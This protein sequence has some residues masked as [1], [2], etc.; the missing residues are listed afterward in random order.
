MLSRLTLTNF[1]AFSGSASVRIAPI[2]LLFGQN[3][4]G[5]SSVLQSLYLLLQTMR[6][7]EPSVALLLRTR[8]GYVDLGSYQ[9]ALYGHDPKQNQMRVRLDVAVGDLPSG[10]TNLR[11]HTFSNLAQFLVTPPTTDP[12][13]IQGWMQHA[14]IESLG[15]EIA[16]D[17][18]DGELTVSGFSLFA[19]SDAE[20]LASY[21][22]EQHSEEPADPSGAGR[23]VTP[24]YERIFV[25]RSKR[26]WTYA[27]SKR[28]MYLGRLLEG[29]TTETSREGESMQAEV[30]F[31]S[32][33]PD[34]DTFIDHQV[35]RLDRATLA[36]RWFLPSSHLRA[37]NIWFIPELRDSEATDDM[38]PW[39][40]P[41]SRS[42][43]TSLASE[44][45]K[46]IRRLLKKEFEKTEYHQIPRVFESLV[47][48]T[49]DRIES[50]LQQARPIGPSRERAA[51]LYL[52][53]GTTPKYVGFAGGDMPEMLFRQDRL[54]DEINQWLDKLDVGYSVEALPIEHSHGGMGNMFEIRLKDLSSPKITVSL[55]DVG[56][57]VTQILPIVVQALA[58]YQQVILVEQPELHVHPGMQT[59][60]GSILAETIHAPHMNTYIIETHSEHLVLRLQRLVREGKLKPSEVSVNFVQRTSSGSTVR[61]LRLD[62]QGE[63]LDDWPGGFFPER[64]RE[65]IE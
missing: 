63:F 4:S 27:F 19:N 3:S 21:C 64:L 49:A 10:S 45:S 9:E 61:E 32:S 23:S 53:S 55:A 42:S 59:R 52:F 28:D 34:I 62:E 39:C 29:K 54:L 60:I 25:T 44:F 5:K 41:T 36:R 17:L 57:G 47:E 26:F 20:P 16:F 12:N 15:L 7:G 65:L 18:L 1:K 33:Q 2:T 46:S 35:N 22:V 11:N 51:R 38:S 58:G 48:I 40:N 50:S 37:V 43:R 6:Y 13:Y 30:A 8:H 14:Q 31:L 24:Q 56:F